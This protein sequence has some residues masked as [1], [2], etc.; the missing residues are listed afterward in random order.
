MGL[1]DLARNLRKDMTPAEA[2]L[3]EKLRNHQLGNY[4][5]RRQ[6]PLLGKY[7]VDFYC[8]KCK[9]I[10]ELEG[11]VHQDPDQKAYDEF[12]A[13][14]LNSK[15]Y[16]VIYFSNDEVIRNPEQVCKIILETLERLKSKYLE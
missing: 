3:W 12:R 5:I 14:I 7:I 15:G 16:T 2:I 1:R 4:G 11:S 8:A 9:L 10:I 13:T 6:T